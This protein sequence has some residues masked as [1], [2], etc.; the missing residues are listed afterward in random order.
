MSAAELGLVLLAGLFAGT[1]NTIVGSGSL[2]TFPL[3]VWLGLPPVQANITSKLGIVPGGLTGTWGYRRELA[4]TRH[5]LP[6]LLV[7]SAVGGLAGALLLL[8]LPAE[9]FDAVVPVLIAVAGVLV[10]TQPMVKRRLAARARSVGTRSSTDASVETRVGERVRATGWLVPGAGA[11][12]V[13]S[14]YF[15]AAQGVLYMAVMGLTTSAG[16]QQ[17][18]ALKN[19]TALVSNAVSAVVFV[20]VSRG[21]IDWAVAGVLAVGALLGGLVGARIGRTLPPA[22]LRGVVLVI[23]VVALWDL[24]R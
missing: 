7:A 3:L 8:V 19:L 22:V 15:G 2:V 17:Q 24:L 9:A 12:G 1:I 11:V 21:S 16:L 4:G 10:A 14:G 20:V 18:N 5:L 23:C 13:Y 6:G